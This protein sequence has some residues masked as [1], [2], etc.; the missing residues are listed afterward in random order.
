MIRIVRP[1]SA[2]RCDDR[3]MKGIDLAGAIS[4]VL[5][6]VLAAV[7]AVLNAGLLTGQAFPTG[8]A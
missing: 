7:M 6:L 2:I 1:A 3:G 8:P 4:T 5:L